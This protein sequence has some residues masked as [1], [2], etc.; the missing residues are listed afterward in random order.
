MP[1][2]WS[3]YRPLLRLAPNSD[4]QSHIRRLFRRSLK[5]SNLEKAAHKLRDGYTVSS[6]RSRRARVPLTLVQLLDELT[7]VQQGNAR[8]RAKYDL[9][10]THLVACRPSPPP[11]AAPS[12][13]PRIHRT[14]GLI[15]AT[16]YNPPLPR[17]KPQ[18]VHISMLIFE[19]RKT[20]QRRWDRFEVA[21]ARAEEGREE[22]RFEERLG[23]EVGEWGA[24]WKREM[25]D[26]KKS[27]TRETRRNE[28]RLVREDGRAR[29]LM[30]ASSRRDRRRS[31]CGALCGPTRTAS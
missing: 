24:E 4:L 6:S 27:F 3:L 30:S 26:M 22:A 9:L 10:T 15:A 12:P 31:F 20:I 14:P 11:P 16:A 2:L 19:R 13:P 29:E 1:V 7:L 5:L 21:K 18:P 8:L 23:V 25:D 28:V 17:L